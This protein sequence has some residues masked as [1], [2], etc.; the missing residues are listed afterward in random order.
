MPG[1]KTHLKERLAELR[2]LIRHHDRCYYLLDRPQISD[3]EYDKLYAEL[4]SIETQHP[5]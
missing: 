1:S 5:E 2:D 4:L 3:L